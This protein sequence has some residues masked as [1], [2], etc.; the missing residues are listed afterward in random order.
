MSVEDCHFVEWKEQF[1]SLE[2]GNRVVHYFLKDST[3]ETILAIIGT[4]RSVRHMFYVVADDFV[5]AFGS[6]TN[7]HVGYKW[8]SRREVVDWLTS[9]IS[10]Q[11]EAPAYDSGKF[12]LV[13][14]SEFPLSDSQGH[15]P[16]ILDGRSSEI[17]WSGTVWTCGKQ[18]RHYPSFSR[19]GITI[20]VHSFVFVMG[21]GENHYLAYL[22]DMYEDKRG[23][24][25]VKVISAECVD[26]PASILSREHFSKCAAALS[27]ALPSKVH[28]CFRQFRNNRVKPFDLTKLRGYFNQ[29]IL[30]CLFLSPM[31]KPDSEWN[32]Q[33]SCEDNEL[34]SGDDVKVG[35][36][37][38]KTSRGDSGIR[39]CWFRCT[40][41]RVAHRQLRVRYDDVKDEDGI[42]N[43]EEWIPA[44]KIARPDKLGMRFSR[45]LTIRPTPPSLDQAELSLDIGVAV[46]VWWSDGWWEGVVIGV[47]NSADD[48]LQIYFPGEN[49][50]MSFHMKDLR[51][52]RDWVGDHWIDIE[53]KPDILS[54]ITSATTTDSKRSSHS[55][56]MRDAL[57][58][59]VAASETDVTVGTEVSVDEVNVNVNVITNSGASSSQA[60]DENT[61][62]LPLKQDRSGKE[63]ETNTVGHNED[64]TVSSTVD[65]SH[66]AENG[67]CDM[68]S[69]TQENDNIVLDAQHAQ[70][71][72]DKSKMVE[73]MRVVA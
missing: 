30:S 36:K 19:N 20:A 37:R 73:P 23:Q 38:A 33:N 49:L 26:G 13:R 14:G 69:H 34:T 15:L 12:E 41:L 24:K 25:K 48:H 56:G 8:R 5:K 4:E 35:G 6:Q 61:P 39:G 54:V 50:F 62:A 59:S 72:I 40:I 29:P 7:I 31:Q 27:H 9:M 65:G 55:T 70:N 11:H 43:I 68:G 18:L 60:M 64:S 2:R 51:I 32:G 66:I 1:V 57:P 16:R 63:S 21:K 53:S 58:D 10:G 45:R 47:N 3:G 28:M 71:L 44:M 52:S 42:A 17:V 67:D 46:D 22:E